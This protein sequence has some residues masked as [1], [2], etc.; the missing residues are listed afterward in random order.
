MY[1]RGEFWRVRW[2]DISPFGAERY[3]SK[4]TGVMDDKSFVEEQRAAILE[5][6]Y[7]YEDE[8]AGGNE[9][10]D[11]YVCF[12]ITFPTTANSYRVGM[13]IPTIPPT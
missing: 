8:D 6:Q 11:E 10:D 1:F 7:E 5:S 12:N 2:K 3:S 13:T 9:Y 4:V